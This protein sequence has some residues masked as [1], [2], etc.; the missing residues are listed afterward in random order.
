M[1]AHTLLASGDGLTTLPR[2]GP[3]LARVVGEWLDGETPVP[4]P[5]PLRRD[6]LT[7]TEV[8]AI[9]AADETVTAALRGDLQTHTTWSD[10][11]ASVREMAEAAHA[12][13]HA[14]LAITDH[15]R[16]LR[17]ARGMTEEEFR[18]QADEIAAVNDALG[19]EHF[20]VLHAAEL[21]LSPSGAGDMASDALARLD[22]VL[23]AFHSALRRTEDQTERY[24]AGLRNPDIQ[25]LAHP[26]GRIYN[27]RL[28]LT[29]DWARVCGVAA[30]LDKAIEIDAY[31]DRQDLN[32]ELLAHARAAG[33]RISIGSDAHSTRELGYIEFGLAAARRA[34]IA[35]DRIVNFLS[36]D[37]LR[38]WVESVRGG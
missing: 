29:A 18:A 6:F 31:P 37:G 17:I 21:N 33:S 24:V 4:E 8:R 32:V 2:V 16:S 20:R 9:L 22:L 23:G 11:K 34:G 28:G 1:E 19:R 13:G 3:F 12:L 30:E 15:T 26:R 10:G 36:A 7:R 5:P 35:H 27:F 25:V 14:Y 38:T